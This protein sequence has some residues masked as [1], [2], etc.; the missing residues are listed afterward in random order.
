MT[1]EE[2]AKL[3]ELLTQAVTQ[4]NCVTFKKVPRDANGKFDLSQIDPAIFERAKLISDL[5]HENSRVGALLRAV[6][7]G[8]IHELGY[9]AHQT[10]D[11]ES[12][13]VATERLLFNVLTASL[14]TGL[15][16]GYKLH[17]LGGRIP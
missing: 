1:P 8:A 5:F 4:A 9:D 16:I 3:Q 17:E 10:G 15:E 6:L 7:K 2:T 14:H 13:Y 11:P 12:V